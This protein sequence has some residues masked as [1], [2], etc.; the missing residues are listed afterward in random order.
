MDEAKLFKEEIKRLEQNL[1]DYLEILPVLNVSERDFER[2]INFM[3]DDINIRKK[4][5]EELK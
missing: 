5:I 3:L 1:K 4:K 2:V